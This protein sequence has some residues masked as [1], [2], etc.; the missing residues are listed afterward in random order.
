MG[1]LAQQLALAGLS[2]AV[3][4]VIE[5]ALGAS[6][7]VTGQQLSE[8]LVQAGLDNEAADVLAARILALPNGAVS[9]A[10][11]D[12]QGGIVGPSGVVLTGAEVAGL[13]GTAEAGVSSIARWKRKLAQSPAAAK[14]VLSGDSTTDYTTSASALTDYLKHMG[15]QPGEGLRGM[16]AA[17]I[18]AL[19]YS[20]MS[21]AVWLA[22][23]TKI[24]ALVSAAPDL[25]V[26][27]WGINDVRLGQC[28]WATLRSRLTAYIDSVHDALP[29][30]DILLR[31][32]NPLLTTN[33]GALNYVQ[34]AQGNVNP[35]GL[36]Q[37][38][39]DLIRTVYL[40][41]AGVYPF[42]QVWDASAEVFGIVSRA[43][44]PLL[45]DQLHP[46]PRGSTFNNVPING[47][48]VEI[49]KALTRQIGAGD[50]AFQL[51]T[52]Q[53]KS[54]RTG[55]FVT[56]AGNG[57]FDIASQDNT[58]VDAAQYPLTTSD[59]VFVQGFDA[60]ISLSGA[61]IFRPFGGNNIRISKTGDWS[62]MVG[63]KMAIAGAH[64]D[65]STGD[66]QVVSVDLPSIAAGATLVVTAAVVGARTGALHDA[67]AVSCTPPASFVS[68]GLVLLNCYPS[69]NDTVS[70]VVLNPT[71]GA[72]DIA[73]ASFAFWVVR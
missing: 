22:D 2:N 11:L 17:N 60:P 50:V 36:A 12:A 66:R 70:L 44:H 6:S 59:V 35:A 19:G 9:S 53:Y 23:P 57:Y 43:T 47:G 15:T 54:F 33:V 39:S 51:S 52:N 29:T 16:Q 7:S 72:V 18:T 73:A 30:C 26:A 49:A 8:A 24:A 4:G 45:A 14:L 10:G 62:A 31:V 21:L 48:Y 67:T 65:A 64:P 56:S 68:A 58:G 69:A 28:D 40:S 41:L 61:S 37:T 27:S 1:A 71:A 42:V 34:D 25:V 63:R 38:Y 46:T 3:A 32:P 55:L 5:N 20:G 13:R